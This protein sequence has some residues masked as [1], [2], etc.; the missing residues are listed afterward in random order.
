MPVRGNLPISFLVEDVLDRD[1]RYLNRLNEGAILRASRGRENGSIGAPQI[2][3]QNLEVLAE[4]CSPPAGW[5]GRSLPQAFIVYLIGHNR[6]L[7]ELLAPACRDIAEECGRG[8]A[9][10]TEVPVVPR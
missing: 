4:G 1:F 2:A 8:F 3:A 9:G 6:P 7:A 5:M 10:M